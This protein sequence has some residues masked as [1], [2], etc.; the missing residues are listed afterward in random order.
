MI[1]F[2]GEYMRY[3]IVAFTI[4]QHQYAAGKAKLL[5]R[6]SEVLQ[7]DE[8]DALVVDILRVKCR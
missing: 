1:E 2:I 8:L 6:A 5:T 3:G 7:R 4:A